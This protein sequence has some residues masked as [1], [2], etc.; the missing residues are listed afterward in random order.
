MG[1][2]A[3]RM[4]TL[5]QQNQRYYPFFFPHILI[6]FQNLVLTLPLETIYQI[7]SANSGATKGFV[8]LCSYIP[9]DLF[10]KTFICKTG[11]VNLLIEKILNHENTALSTT[12][13]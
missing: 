1:N 8:F 12:H 9:Q 7:H 10:K 5:I 3:T 2:L 6:S 13:L 11:S 4:H